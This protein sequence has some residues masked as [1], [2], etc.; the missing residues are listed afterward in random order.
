MSSKVINEDDLACDN[1]AWSRPVGVSPDQKVSLLQHKEEDEKQ[2]DKPTEKRGLIL[3]FVILLLSIPA[4]IGAWCWPALVLGLITG[5]VSAASRVASHWISFGITLGMMV[6][7][8]LYML[9]SLKKRSP[10]MGKIQRYGPLVCVLIAVPLIMA[11]LVRH[12]LQDTNIWPE[13][14]R[15]DG[16]TW[17]SN[18]FWS[19]SQY[20]CTLAPPH[21]IPD[22]DE[23][24]LHLSFIGV[25]FTIIFTYTGF[26]FLMIGSFWN[27]NIISKLRLI[28]KK[29][30]EL[31]QQVWTPFKRKE[32]KKG[33][34]CWGISWCV[35]IKPERGSLLRIISFL[36]NSP[37]FFFS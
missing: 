25:L 31:R 17:G 26:V 37:F 1:G 22:K 12:V 6:L 14:E 34:D 10:K 19:S 11:D 9:Y 29:W 27:A 35:K 28:R 5:S 21:C 36:F 20:H 30:K 15:A 23:N 13:C 2:T 7:I 18:C 16:Q 33:R 3:S 8:V 4:L 32:R 24:L